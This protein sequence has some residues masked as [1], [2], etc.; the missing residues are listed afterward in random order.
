[1]MNIDNSRSFA[2][3]ENLIASLKKNGL[4]NY[5]FVV[6]KNTENRWTAIFPNSFLPADADRFGIASRG[7]MVLG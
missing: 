6:V 4:D 3:Q 5:K 1:M 2:T 7:F